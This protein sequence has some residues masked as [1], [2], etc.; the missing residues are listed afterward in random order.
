MPPVYGYRPLIEVSATLATRHVDGRSAV[1][2][3]AFNRSGHANQRSNMRRGRPDGPCDHRA[4]GPY[5]QPCRRN[6]G[7]CARAATCRSGGYVASGVPF[8]PLRRIPRAFA[9]NR[10]SGRRIGATNACANR[11]PP[12]RFS[13]V[14]LGFPQR[15]GSNREEIQC[16]AAIGRRQEARKRTDA[17]MFY[18]ARRATPQ[19]ARGGIGR[20]GA[21]MVLRFSSALCID[22]GCTCST[23]EVDCP[24]RRRGCST[25]PQTVVSPRR[26]W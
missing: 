12:R 18:D 6:R 14:C 5:R 13:P 26:E 9:G 16:V 3:E 4:P 15:R 23:A 21:S 25:M 1:K 20:L 22:G 24:W 17:D 7:H 19:H 2:N 11:N 8:A 10:C